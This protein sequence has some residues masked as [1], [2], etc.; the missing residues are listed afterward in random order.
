LSQLFK[1]PDNESKDCKYGV[2]SH[3]PESQQSLNLNHKQREKIFRK[4]FWNIINTAAPD[5]GLESILADI[6]TTWLDWDLHSDWIKGWQVA[7]QKGQLK[8]LVDSYIEAMFNGLLKKSAESAMLADYCST[9]NQE[10]QT[11]TIYAVTDFLALNQSQEFLKV[12]FYYG[13]L[14]YAQRFEAP[15]L[16]QICQ[17]Y[18]WILADV[19]GILCILPWAEAAHA[20]Q[21]NGS[22]TPRQE[23]QARPGLSVPIAPERYQLW[24][25]RNLA[26]SK[27]KPAGFGI[28]N[29]T[30]RKGITRGRK[31]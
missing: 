16:H 18:P 26:K 2:S 7:A 25:P 23:I 21:K 27:P 3:Q 22:F 19:L 11:R 28:I 6:K 24:E 15:P 4:Y 20:M 10:V 29:Y 1:T 14:D 9:L 8:P 12:L 5:L 30:D 13:L 31:I 17:I